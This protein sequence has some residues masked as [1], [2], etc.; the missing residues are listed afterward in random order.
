MKRLKQLL[1][2]FFLLISPLLIW[3]LDININ[4]PSRKVLQNLKEIEKKPQEAQPKLKQP[5]AGREIREEFVKK[6]M[7]KTLPQITKANKK[8]KDDFE[9]ELRHRGLDSSEMDFKSKESYIITKVLKRHQR[10]F[11]NKTRSKIRSAKAYYF[12]NQYN[13]NQSLK[14]QLEPHE[15]RLKHIPPRIYFRALN[16]L[17]QKSVCFPSTFY[18]LFKNELEEVIK[19]N[20]NKYLIKHVMILPN[21]W[22]TFNFGFVATDALRDK[23]YNYANEGINFRADHFKQIENFDEL[24]RSKLDWQT[25]RE[26]LSERM[27]LNQLEKEF[28]EREDLHYAKLAEKRKMRE[29]EEPKKKPEKEQTK[30][31]KKKVKKNIAQEIK[32]ELNRLD[33]KEKQKIFNGINTL[34]SALTTP[35]DQLES[36]LLDLDTQSDEYKIYSTAQEINGSLLEVKNAIIGFLDFGK[37][38]NEEEAVQKV[39]QFV[40]GMQ[41]LDFKKL[42]QKKQTEELT[43][44]EEE[45]FGEYMRVLEEK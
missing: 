28:Q 10:I 41:S 7:I 42:L 45:K 21:S 11:A 2:L 12:P 6:V 3:T 25:F 30:A 29:K 44:K 37:V 13:K 31:K 39:S 20:D 27:V 32:E 24:F 4:S 15:K 40:V 17:I 33:D 22:N 26:V 23:I 19:T 18:D 8:C 43:P 35:E 5:E 36:T 16:L 38:K 1:I 9:Y 34:Y 14:E